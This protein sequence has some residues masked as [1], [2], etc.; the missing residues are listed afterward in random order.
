[1]ATAREV[2][3]LGK[4]FPAPSVTVFYDRDRCRHHAECARGLPAVF[5]VKRRPWTR[6]ALRRCG[7]TGNEPLCDGACSVNRQRAGPGS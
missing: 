6:A 5:D 1:M 7:S 2:G 3:S 4:A